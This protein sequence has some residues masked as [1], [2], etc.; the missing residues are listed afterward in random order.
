MKSERK[1]AGNNEVRYVSWK[2]AK[3]RQVFADPEMFEFALESIH[4]FSQR[5]ETGKLDSFIILPDEI[6]LLFYGTYREEVS[7][8]LMCIENDILTFAWEWLGEDFGLKCFK[9]DA[10]V[11]C[12]EYSDQ[13]CVDYKMMMSSRLDLWER[14]HGRKIPGT[15]KGINGVFLNPEEGETMVIVR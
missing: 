8:Y 1:K 13:K 2:S 10:T 3:G 4:M 14:K 12:F 6:G 11:T 15:K 9:P 7:E 5:L